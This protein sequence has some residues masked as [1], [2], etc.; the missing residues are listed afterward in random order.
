MSQAKG[1]D[2]SKL[3][4]S[5]KILMGGGIAYLIVAFLPWQRACVD[6]G[7]LGSIC[8][9]AAGS[10][11]VGI[12]NI[13]LAIA[14]IAWEGMTLAGVEMKAPKGLVSAGLAGALLLFTILK[15]VVDSESIYFFSWIGLI[16]GLVI[17]YGGWM[18][19]QAHQASGGSSAG[20][21][22]PPPP[23]A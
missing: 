23:S 22:M 15:I 1:F 4:T 11:G 8:V 13:L 6:A 21:A 20:G 2:L 16:I 18:A 7:P 9:K 3:S 14:L 5:S 12:I 10:S 19:Y 17:A